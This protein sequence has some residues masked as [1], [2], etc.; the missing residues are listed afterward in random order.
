VRANLFSDELTVKK[1]WFEVL[2]LEPVVV[3]FPFRLM[4]DAM[5]MLMQA[6]C[7]KI[8]ECTRSKERAGIETQDASR[9]VIL[10]TGPTKYSKK[11][12]FVPV[13]RCEYR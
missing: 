3:S 9:K 1:Y 12:G 5:L 10:S 13:L 2:L 6:N 4:R 8:V 7:Y 11:R